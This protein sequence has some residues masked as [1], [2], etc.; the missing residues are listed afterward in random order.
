M[1]NKLYHCYGVYDW[2]AAVPGAPSSLRLTAVQRDAV[3]LSWEPA[4]TD[5]GAPITGYLV[6]RCDATRG[7][8]GWATIG[9]LD[10]STFSFR[11]TK[12]L[13]GNRYHFRV[14]AE[15]AVG[16]GQ[17]IETTHAVE[18]KSPFGQLTLNSTLKSL[19]HTETVIK[20]QLKF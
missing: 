18:V 7:G 3:T 11:A 17:P 13:E 14:T 5:G 10:A 16:T 8:A 6:E 2:P 12:L 9:H 1:T 4:E 15:N 20:L 19:A